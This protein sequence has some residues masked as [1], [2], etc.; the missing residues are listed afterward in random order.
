MNNINNVSKEDIYQGE[1]D[2]KELFQILSQSKLLIGFVSS[3]FLALSIGYSLYLPNIYQSQAL[4]V[5]NESSSDISGAFKSVGGL[6]SLAGVSLPSQGDDTNSLK[7]IEKMNSLSFFES[8]ILPNISLPNLMALKSWNPN[9]NSLEYYDNI[10]NQSSDKWVRD[11]AYPQ[12]LKPSA[13][14]SYEEFKA[15]HFSISEDKKT[16][17][18]TLSIKHQSPHVAYEWVELFVREINSFY[19]TKD[20]NEADISVDYLNNQISKTNLAE[21]KQVLASLLQQEIQKLTLI[22]A[23]EFYVYEYIDPPVVMEYKSEPKRALICILGLLLGF[24]LSILIVLFRYYA[25][26]K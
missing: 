16:G 23:S 19:R 13:Q 10:Y 7:A 3:F 24:M 11:Y 1:I 25:K 2:L 9:L 20:R 21:V 17:F 12:K 5:S 4:L 15:E 6:A 22:Q 8:N 18:I 26:T 14:E